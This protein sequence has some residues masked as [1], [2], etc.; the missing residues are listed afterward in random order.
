MPDQPASPEP[1]TCSFCG[2]DSR[3]S[4]PLSGCPA[5]LAERK[6]REAKPPPG[7]VVILED[8]GDPD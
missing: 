4:N 1:Y 2:W 6:R 8:D 5:C 7:R 3:Y